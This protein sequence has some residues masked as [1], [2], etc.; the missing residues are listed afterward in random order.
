MQS[1]PA[2]TTSFFFFLSVLWAVLLVGS[3]AHL[4]FFGFLHLHHVISWACCHGAVTQG[5]TACV[6]KHGDGLR[7]VDP[8][9]LVIRLLHLRVLVLKESF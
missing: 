6:A 9:P 2:H 4:V 7:I 8:C 3:L 1:I 5:E